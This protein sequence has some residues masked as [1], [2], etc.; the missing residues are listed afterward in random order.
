[1]GSSVYGFLIFLREIDFFYFRFTARR[2]DVVLLSHSHGQPSTTL[3][4]VTMAAHNAQHAD[5][6]YQPGSS[7]IHR[8]AEKHASYDAEFITADPDVK[9]VVFAVETSGALHQEARQF[10]LDHVTFLNGTSSKLSLQR[11]LQTIS[12][13]IQTC[14]AR[15]VALAR[16]HLSLDEEPAFPYTNG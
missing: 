10:L 8:A 4:D 11:A 1:M 14:R 7:A 3:I 13:S 6:D 2:A 16:S 15:C 12:V 9:L 5:P